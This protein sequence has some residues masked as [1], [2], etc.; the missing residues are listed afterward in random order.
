MSKYP[1]YITKSSNEWQYYTKR[2]KLMVATIQNCH[3]K[4][5]K[6]IRV[7]CP[8]SLLQTFRRSRS[9]SSSRTRPTKTTDQ[10]SCNCSSSCSDNRCATM[11]DSSPGG[12]VQQHSILASIADDNRLD[13]LFHTFDRRLLHGYFHSPLASGANDNRLE[14]LLHGYSHSPLYRYFQL[15]SFTVI[16]FNYLTNSYNMTWHVHIS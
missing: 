5:K 6:F 3:N 16:T 1:R 4:R 11:D 8:G 13:Q 7:Q 10:R 12:Q 15:L 2:A 14:Q 9:W